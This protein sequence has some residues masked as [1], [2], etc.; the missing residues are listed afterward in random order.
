MPTLFLGVASS[1]VPIE[2]LAA[3]QTSRERKVIH[4]Y[5]YEGV[6]VILYLLT[7]LLVNDVMLPNA[8]YLTGSISGDVHSIPF[9]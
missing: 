1:D 7:S 4:P 3:R 2:Y 8:L 6:V 5:M 9:H